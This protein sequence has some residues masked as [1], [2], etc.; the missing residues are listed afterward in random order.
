MIDRNSHIGIIGSGRLGTNLAIVLC[1]N[2]YDKVSITCRNISS[3]KSIQ[4]LLPN[5][6]IFDNN[7]DL[8][9]HADLIIIC[10]PDHQITTVAE[11]TTW[12]A[13]QSVIHC[14]GPLSYDVL[15]AVS[16]SGASIG[17]FHPC[18][19]FTA[20]IDLPSINNLFEGTLINVSSDSAQLADALSILSRQIG[21]IP[22]SISDEFRPLYH[23]AAV[24]TCGSLAAL[25]SISMA[26]WQE[27]GL[28]ESEAKSALKTLSTTTLANIYEHG[29]PSSL[30]GPILREDF[31][32]IN[33]HLDALMNYSPDA[34]AV[35]ALL[36][37]ITSDSSGISREKHIEP[38][39]ISHR[40]TDLI[41]RISSCLAS[42]R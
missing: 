39:D 26:I 5:I 25:M 18:Q 4:Q 6:S 2:G 28:T 36:S 41:E 31:G 22:I 20:N 40:Y 34:A 21:G 12:Q 7:Q 23:V 27:I 30:T 19:T 38:N 35:Y 33:S 10:T 24:L 32:T 11:H 14:S 42:P 9:N 37:K 15:K 8:A 1:N 13:H 29:I 17:T 3:Y 16:E